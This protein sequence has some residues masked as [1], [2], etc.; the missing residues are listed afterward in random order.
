MANQSIPSRRRPFKR[1][2]D[3]AQGFAGLRDLTTTLWLP[4]DHGRVRSGEGK[5]Q[6]SKAFE[7]THV[8]F[9][10]MSRNIVL[11]FPIAACTFLTGC[12]GINPFQRHTI[13]PANA[14]S[15]VAAKSKTDK[16]VQLVDFSQSDSE[17]VTEGLIPSTYDSASLNERNSAPAL[18]IALEPTDM[19]Q[20]V[21]GELSLDQVLESVKEC[22]PEIEIAVGEIE[23]ANGKVLSSWGEFDQV[24]TGHSISHPLGFYQTYRNG[25]GINRP[26]YSGGEVYGTYRI[27][28]GN[29]EPWFGERETNEGGEI[30]AGFS[31]PLLK[32]RAIDQ[33]R[34]KLLASGAQQEQV[35][36]NVE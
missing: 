21:S 2:D 27:G 35:E 29:F 15:F 24:V 34:A 33:R 30:K 8:E 16:A 28:D 4:G 1:L 14:T 10:S 5:G 31:V 9:T 22:Y 13:Q 19:G 36:S 20:D 23:T 11:S 32:D 3:A 25:V 12:S 7:V 17:N 26:L 6:S 18:D